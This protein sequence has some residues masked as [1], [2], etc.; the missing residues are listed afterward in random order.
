MASLTQWTWI[1]ANLGRDWRTG[2]PGMLHS[3]ESQ[4]LG[5]NWATELNWLIINGFR[6]IL[7][8]HFKSKGNPKTLLSSLEYHEGNS[9][10]K[11]L[12]LFYR[13]LLDIYYDFRE[14]QGLEEIQTSSF[15]KRTCKAKNLHYINTQN[16]SWDCNAL[17]TY[18]DWFLFSSHH[19]RKIIM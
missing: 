18:L 8:I 3:M 19:H 5:H 12:C 10:Q 11:C 14:G 15:L 1:W 7:K 2:K 4:I 16:L 13:D 6:Y 9:E 17:P